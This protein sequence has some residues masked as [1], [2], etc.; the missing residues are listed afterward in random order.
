MSSEPELDATADVVLAHCLER[1]AT[2]GRGRLIGVDGPAGA[3]KST[4]AEVVAGRARRQVASV[5]LLHLDDLYEGWSGLTDELTRRIVEDILEPL[6]QGLPGRYRRWDW[7]ADAWAEE[8]LVDPCSLLILEGVG[9]CARGYDHL[10]TTRVW[11]DA[12]R[13]LRSARGE[14]RGGEGMVENWERW[15]DQEQRHLAAE[16]TQS[17]ADILVDGT[18]EFPPQVRS[19][20]GAAGTTR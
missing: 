10:V 4:L 7:Y 11:V 6:A 2:L 20:P 14:G 19:H 3:G 8:H 9:A 1:P 13:E 5:D 12:P 18:G 17:R 16:G 15:L